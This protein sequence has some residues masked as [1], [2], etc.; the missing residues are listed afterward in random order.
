MQ[1]LSKREIGNSAYID[2]T[3]LYKGSQAEGYEIDYM[4]LRTY[5]KERHHVTKAYI[6]I[7]FVARNRGLYKELQDAGYILIFKPTIPHEGGLKGNCDAELVLQATIDFFEHRYAKAVIVTSDGDFS[8]L[9]S[10]LKEKGKLDAVLSPRS[11]CRCSSLIRQTGARLTFLPEVKEKI[12]KSPTG[13][14][15]PAGHTL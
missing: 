15:T 1:R 14:E 10:F 9:V 12:R 7:G 5:L 13:D 6:F 11:Q 3:N 4:R 8:C 2:N